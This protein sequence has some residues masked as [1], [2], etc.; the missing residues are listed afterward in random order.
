M[1]KNK[2]KFTIWAEYIAVRAA[3]ATISVLPEQLAVFTARVLGTLAWLVRRKSR[4]LAQQNLRKAM[5]GEL[6]DRE[7]RRIARRVLGAR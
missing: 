3:A 5:P 2:S 1:T 6:S 4:R 7:I